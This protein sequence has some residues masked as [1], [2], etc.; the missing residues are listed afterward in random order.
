MSLA[1]WLKNR[2]FHWSSYW[3]VYWA[4]KAVGNNSK[5]YILVCELP[6]K[7]AAGQAILLVLHQVKKRNFAIWHAT[8][9]PI[10]ISFGT[11][12]ETTERSPPTKF[13]PIRSRT[14]RVIQFFVSTTSWDPFHSPDRLFP[15]KL[16]THISPIIFCWRWKFH[17]NQVTWC[18]ATSTIQFLI[19]GSDHP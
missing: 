10:S 3:S 11:V 18:Q 17:L 8:D 14:H 9:R 16:L 4:N 6:I 2:F 13:Q 15:P 12:L 7:T 5:H 19:L 1:F